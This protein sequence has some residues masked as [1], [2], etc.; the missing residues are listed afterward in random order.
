MHKMKF[1][2]IFKI[3]IYFEIEDFYNVKYFTIFVKTYDYK[4]YSHIF[5]YKNLTTL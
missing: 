1:N 3:S 4:N 5:I 2:I